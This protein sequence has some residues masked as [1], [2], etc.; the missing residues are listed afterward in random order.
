MKILWF[1][2]ILSI[3]NYSAMKVAVNYH[4]NPKA[5]RRFNNFFT[6]LLLINGAVSVISAYS[7]FMIFM[8]GSQEIRYVAGTMLLFGIVFA[9]HTF[10]MRRGWNKIK[11]ADSYFDITNDVYVFKKTLFSWSSET[12]QARW[13][14]KER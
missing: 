4:F 2:L 9:I 6:L 13:F 14:P 12:K 11:N 5:K 10:L 3:V 1:L 7:A 8:Y